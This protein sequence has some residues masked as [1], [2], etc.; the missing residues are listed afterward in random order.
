M[1]IVN[2]T[3]AARARLRTPQPNGYLVIAA[4]IGRWAGPFA[5]PAR[6]LRARQGAV[7][8]AAAELEGRP[9][10][11]SVAVFRA[12]LRPPGEGG[13]LLRD[14]GRSAARFDLVVVVRTVDPD[15]ARTLRDDAQVRD[16]AQRVGS[17]AHRVLTIAA[18]NAARI[19]DV[20]HA[21][22]RPVLFNFFYAD[23]RDTLIEVWR[24]TAGWFQ[25]RTS[26][27]NSVLLRPLDGESGDYGL[28]NFASWPHYRTFLPSLLLRPSFRSFVLANFRANGV[29]AQPIIYRSVAG[30]ARASRRPAATQSR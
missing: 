10:I 7:I 15:H 16:L 29:A 4:E 25:E 12:V 9:D 11:E 27:S 5:I 23:D 26:L 6:S 19:D 18:S 8:R 30:A 3:R 24:Y 20:E 28:V 22:G 1:Q 13:R 2:D 17:G 21:D 14:R